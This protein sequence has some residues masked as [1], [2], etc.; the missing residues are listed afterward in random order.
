MNRL[1]KELLS[2]A[3][4][5]L[6]GA[7]GEAN[8]D[9]HRDRS[10]TGTVT[11]I[12]A[13]AVRGKATGAGAVLGGIAGG[14]LGHQVGSGRGNDLA[15]V[16]GAVGGAV[17]GHQIEERRAERPSRYNIRVRLDDGRYRGFHQDNADDIRVGDRVLVENDRIH[18]ERRAQRSG[19][20]YR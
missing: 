13:E 15:T 19:A 16:A 2:L 10:R 6:I 5:V 4:V 20:V 14:V 12:Q 3:T 9:V 8:A 17:V 1:S 11:S 7:N 18:L